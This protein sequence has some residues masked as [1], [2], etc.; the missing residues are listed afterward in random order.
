MKRTLLSLLAFTF[1]QF[2]N[3]AQPTLTKQWDAGFGGTRPDLLTSFLQTRDG[4]YMLAGYSK[5]LAGGDKTQT[6][7]GGTGDDDYWIVKIDTAGNKEWDKDFGGLFSDKLYAVN[8]MADG[9]YLL[10]GHSISGISGDKTQPVQGNTDYW[11]L[12]TD[13][14]GIKLWDKDFG[15][16]DYDY[17]SCMIATNDGGYILG[18][19]SASLA[20]GD[21][22][23]PSWGGWDFWIVKIDAQGNK[24]WDKDFG[25]T[26]HDYLNAIHQTSD[27]GYL[28]G[29]YSASDISGD[30]TENRWGLYDYWI[31]KTDS[32]GNFQWDKDFGGYSNDFINSVYQPADGGYILAGIS[33]SNTGGNKSQDSW[34]YYDFWIIKTDSA[35]NKLWDK[36]Y[37]G[38]DD[39]EFFGNITPFVNGDLMLAGISYSNISGNK[40]ENNLGIEQSWILK[41][42]SA[43]NILW[44]KT[45]FT[46]GHDEE[47]Y[48]IVTSDGCIA[49][50]NQTTGGIAGYKSMP[51]R[52]TIIQPYTTADYWIVKF[53]D[54]TLTSGV[55]NTYQHGNAKVYP[56]PAKDEL[57]IIINDNEFYEISFYDIT[58]RN[59]IHQ[60]FTASI[61]IN[62]EKLNKG[63]YFYEIRNKNS[64]ISKGKIIKI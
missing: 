3:N 11:I 30:K 53:C 35:G 34:G 59:L 38:T 2:T 55:M 37:G 19:V 8:Q 47:G 40:T 41:I 49:V 64:V 4:G 12:K 6:L 21:K 45:I 27:G 42:D 24:I 46:D 44:D 10:A 48:S 51:N 17:L 60:Y 23:Q 39:D 33:E 63:I 50:A 25:G 54:T 22:S 56:N 9:G 28:L 26:E 1:F 5:S 62:I 36:D 58:S 16:T 31:V 61:K 20:G 52:D 15:G 14:S 32:L 7:W 18:G 29:G 13:S 43:G 57:N